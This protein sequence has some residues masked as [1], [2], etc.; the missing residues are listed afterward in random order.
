MARSTLFVFSAS[1]VLQ[2]KYQTSQNKFRSLMKSTNFLSNSFNVFLLFGG[3]IGLLFTL[4]AVRN[5][6]AKDPSSTKY[7]IVNKIFNMAWLGLFIQ[8]FYMSL[9]ELNLNTAIQVA[10]MN[11]STTFSIF[12]LMFCGIMVAFEVLV[13][14]YFF[15]EHKEQSLL[16]EKYRDQS[17]STFWH[18]GSDRKF[19]AKYYWFWSAGKKVVLPFLYVCL[20]DKPHTLITA[21][22]VTQAI[23]LILTVYCE[24]YERK[25]L[26]LSVY[27][28]ETL[29]L[30]TYV[31]L[32]NF[33]EKYVNY[34][35]LVPITNMVYLLIVL[36]FAGHTLFIVGNIILEGQIYWR[37]IRR[38]LGLEVQK[39]RVG[40]YVMGKLRMYPEAV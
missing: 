13:V 8:A 30:L 34:L 20:Q 10:N 36:T 23:W 11:I 35:P 15:K 1:D 18:L 17:Y 33:S 38:K 24:P 3:C 6:W 12:G 37:T 40:G 29:K 28:S 21:V 9:I 39:M 22:A 2:A 14:G 27:A 5:C 7:R 32:T 19:I 4:R 26:R 25:Y 16:K 31:A